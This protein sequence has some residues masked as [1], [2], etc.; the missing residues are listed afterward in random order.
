MKKRP[1]IPVFDGPL[2]EFPSMAYIPEGV[3]TVCLEDTFGYDVDL[4]PCV[5]YSSRDGETQ[6]LHI[7]VPR[8]REAA[9]IPPFSPASP[10]TGS[11]IPTSTGR[12][13]VP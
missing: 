9:A 5:P 13:P 8:G 12:I 3:R 11:R 2:E 4:I 7:L 1:L 10:A 6:Q